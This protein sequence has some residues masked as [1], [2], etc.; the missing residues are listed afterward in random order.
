[1]R[2]RGRVV[3]ASG[4]VTRCYYGRRMGVIV[5]PNVFGDVVLVLII[6]DQKTSFETWRVCRQAHDRKKGATCYVSF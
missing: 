3:N 1:M 6:F 2:A 4:L 5:S